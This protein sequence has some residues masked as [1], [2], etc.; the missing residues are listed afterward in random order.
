MSA[1][2]TVV[3]F[4]HEGTEDKFC[5]EQ[6]RFIFYFLLSASPQKIEAKSNF[7]HASAVAQP[8]G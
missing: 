7:L 5:G 4:A 8:A 2:V 1:T 3:A 6:K